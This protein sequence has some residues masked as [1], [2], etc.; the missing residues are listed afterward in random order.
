[1]S[2]FV[3]QIITNNPQIIRVGSGMKKSLITY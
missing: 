2:G 3:K 1:M